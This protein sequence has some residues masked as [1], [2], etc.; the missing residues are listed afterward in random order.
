[1]GVVVPDPARWIAHQ[2]AALLSPGNAR[3]LLRERRRRNGVRY[4]RLSLRR[5]QAGRAGMRSAG[6]R[7]GDRQ[8]AAQRGRVRCF[9]WRSQDAVVVCNNRWRQS[10]QAA[11]EAPRGGGVESRET[12]ATSALTYNERRNRDSVKLH[13]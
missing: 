11:G 7:D 10:L 6:P 13:L 9:L 5:D 8:P 2:W 4:R 3:R 12:A 1:M